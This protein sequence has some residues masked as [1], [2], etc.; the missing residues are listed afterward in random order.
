MG[1]TQTE[2]AERMGLSMSYISQLEKGK[3]TPSE[4]VETLVGMIETQLE[5]GMISGGMDAAARKHARENDVCKLNES[6]AS[7]YQAHRSRMIPLVSWAHAGE[8]ES[9]EELPKSWQ[10]QVPT[11]CRDQNAYGLELRGDSMEGTGRCFQEGDI[12]I[13]SPNTEPFNG[14]LA[15]VRFANDG[16]L[17]RRYEL[18]QGR[19]RLVPL[20]HRY[21]T[22]EHEPGDITWIHPVYGR[23]TQIL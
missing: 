12:L 3:R 19:I 17:F 4:S 23:W 21:E 22:T 7:H 16:I 14:C 8:A 13:I 10:K 5:A 6:S 11:E 2:M 20:N 9:Y 1:L 15:V 18:N